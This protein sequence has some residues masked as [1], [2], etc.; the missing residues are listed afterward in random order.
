MVKI[1]IRN[2]FYMSILLKGK[3]IDN[4]SFQRRGLFA[5]ITISLSYCFK[6]AYQKKQKFYLLPTD[7][8]LRKNQS[9][10][11]CYNRQRHKFF[12]LF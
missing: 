8:R 2:P 11:C 10:D 5:I 6:D 1:K 9:P 3:H 12:S 4:N 7:G